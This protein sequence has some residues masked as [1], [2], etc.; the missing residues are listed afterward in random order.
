MPSVYSSRLISVRVVSADIG[1]VLKGLND[2]SVTLHHLQC[3]DELTANFK[4]SRG[5]Y[6][7]A[8]AIIER[9]GGK[10]RSE[11]EAV[12]RT[13]LYQ[14]LR[15]P[16]LI[17]G[18]FLI[19]GLSCY[20][21]SKVLF[22]TVTGNEHISSNLILEAASRCGIHFG[23]SRQRIRSEKVKNELLSQ[24]PEL[25]W[26]GIN[27]R[28]CIAEISVRERLL[29]ED[30]EDSSV[31]SSIIASRDGIISELTVTGGE[32]ACSVG[33]AVEKGDLLISG[34]SDCGRCIYGTRSEGEVFA[35][36]QRS[37]EAFTPVFTTQRI[38]LDGVR[39]NI[40]L[41]I[42]KKR[43]NFLNCSG[44]YDTTCVKMYTEYPLTLPGDW[45]LPVAL[46]VETSMDYSVTD[47][48]REEDMISA[49]LETASREYLNEQM[50]AGQINREQTKVLMESDVM[51]LTGDYLCHEMIGQTH[52]EE[53]IEHY[54]ESN[55]K[56][57][58]RR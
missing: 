20:L 34:Y 26:A 48:S 4:V 35:H 17:I 29:S 5:Q 25:K 55:G 51:M 36:T 31:I 12:Q 23:A 41:I 10:L 18:L 14:I 37:L 33:Q 3:V 21:P 53:I 46:A 54:G 50:I 30:R 1:S 38:A 32:A 2:H 24:I 44:I 57:G 40:S 6:R 45:I 19:I 16:V 49:F 52:I 43:I 7:T 22:V 15:R 58:E 28:G 13:L 27:T 47:I 11:D 8:V 42:G 39:R 56:N 9:S